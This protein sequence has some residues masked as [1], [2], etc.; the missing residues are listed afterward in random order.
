MSEVNTYLLEKQEIGYKAAMELR[1]SAEKLARN[2]DFKKLILKHF[3][4][5]EC[6]L[7]AQRSADP[8]LNEAQRAD[9]LAISQAAG[10]L[11]RFLSVIVQMG[12]HAETEMPALAEALLEARNAEDAESVVN[13]QPTEE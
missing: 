2:N 6:A 13:T 4:V 11:K 5:E 3:M 9:A 7:Y 10:H 8:Q 1:D 12:N